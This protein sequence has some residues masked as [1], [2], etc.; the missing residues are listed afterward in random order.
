MMGFQFGA[1]EFRP[2]LWPS[3]AA[4]LFFLLTLFLGNWQTHRAEYKRMLQA[5]YD[6]GEDAEP[7][8]LGKEL[9][10]KESLLFHRVEA[11]GE[12][13]QSGQILIDN[14]V[15]NGVPGY[16]VLE[17]LHLSGSGLFVLVNRGWVA[18]GAD[19]NHLPII[20]MVIGQ[21]RI[22]GIA[23]DPVSRYFE[24]AGAEPRNGV[25]Q[26]LNFQ[27]YR[28]DFAKPLQP[29]LI[30]QTSNTPD[31][32]YRQWPRPDAGVATHVSYALQ[33]YGLAAT[34]VVLF[35]ALNLKKRVQS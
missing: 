2:G 32:L 13:D 25:W 35:L 4:L 9:Q 23:V 30:Q 10:D 11:R 33:W 20:P 34:I 6:Q 7:I 29:I 15:V 14:R 1:Y 24:F 19:R 16:H 21:I 3:L 28:R 26:N 22:V 31:G 17:P 12:F 18:A 8:H 27:R 5:R